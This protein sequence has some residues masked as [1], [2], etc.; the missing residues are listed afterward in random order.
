MLN[1][2]P[3]D[4]INIYKG[5][6]KGRWEAIDEARLFSVLCRERTR[7]SGLKLEYGE[8]PYSYKHAEELLYS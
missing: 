7:S 6:S 1:P 4:L 2:R 5:L 8:F 3:G